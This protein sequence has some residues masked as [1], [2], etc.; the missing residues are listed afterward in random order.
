MADAS[1]EI[2]DERLNRSVREHEETV[3]WAYRPVSQELYRWFDIFN[4]ELFR[5]GLDA[6]LLR[7][8]R[9]RSSEIAK[10]RPGR[11]GMG[12]R[13]EILFNDRYT[14]CSRIHVLAALLHALAHA[15]QDFE[16]RSGRRNYH[17]RE[18]QR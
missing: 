1:F 11:N 9:Y 18:F 2:A 8:D 12:G 13:H 16:G 14:E 10:Y 4:T 15:A 6:P 3:A 7:V 17:N 5:G